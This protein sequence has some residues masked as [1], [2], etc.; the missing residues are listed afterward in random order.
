M[1]HRM[2][3][4]SISFVFFILTSF[5]VLYPQENPIL[6][7]PDIFVEKGIDSKIAIPISDKIREIFVNSKKYQIIDRATLNLVIEE[8]KFQLSDLVDKDQTVKIGKLLGAQ[9]IAAGNVT[10][11]EDQYTMSIRIIDVETGV[12]ISQVTGNTRGSLNELLDLTEKLSNKIV[13]VKPLSEQIGSIYIDANIEESEIFLDG[14]RAGKIPRLIENVQ[15][16]YHVL[17]VKKEN[18]YYQK[19]IE[20]VNR[21]VIEVYAVLRILKGNLFIQSDPSNA[22]IF[23]DGYL[24]GTTPKLIKNIDTG[25]HRLSLDKDWYKTAE[26]MVEIKPYKTTKVSKDLAKIGKLLIKIPANK[27]EIEKIT[28]SIGNEEYVLPKQ[29]VE[30]NHSFN[31]H[32]GQYRLTAIGKNIEK[33]EED[34]FI[35][36]GIQREVIINTQFSSEYIEEQRLLKEERIRIEKD[37]VK[38]RL[39][40]NLDSLKQKRKRNT[41]A[42]LIIGGCSLAA[43]GSGV[44][45]YFL[46]KAQVNQYNDYYDLYQSATVTTEAID[47]RNTAQE[48]YDRSINLKRSANVFTGIAVVSAGVSSLFIIFRPQKAEIHELER[49]IEKYSSISMRSGF[50]IRL[51]F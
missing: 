14:I 7:V 22:S 45:F 40:T 11:I 33:Y 1:K 36:K 21:N 15:I 39:M 26:E 9:F 32:E 27:E 51:K 37:E 19:E 31:F 17:E 12:I 23:I 48:H 44:L 3:K 2:L 42:G 4:I 10:R 18:Y 34:V 38:K 47:Y 28:M 46:S 41:Q 35:E 8:Q 49:K 5:T 16:G 20:I 24:I 50:S 6:A 13:G 43:T 30:Q 29:L 25:F